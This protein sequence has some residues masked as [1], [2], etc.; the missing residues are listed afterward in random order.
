LYRLFE[1]NR[2]DLNFF[3]FFIMKKTRIFLIIPHATIPFRFMLCNKSAHVTTGEFR[4][5]RS[6]YKRSGRGSKLLRRLAG[7]FTTSDFEILGRG[8]IPMA[9]KHIILV[10]AEALTGCCSKKFHK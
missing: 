1:A 2:A 9:F 4:A 3:A 6:A 10:P 8:V 7:E 5:C